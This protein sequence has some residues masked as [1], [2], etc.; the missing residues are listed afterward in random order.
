[1]VLFLFESDGVGKFCI[2]SNVIG[3]EEPW[4]IKEAAYVLLNKSIYCLACI[5]RWLKHPPSK[6]VRFLFCTI[7]M[8]FYYCYIIYSTSMYH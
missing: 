6:L 4:L 3:Q 5:R 1:M 2:F 7:G 8:G